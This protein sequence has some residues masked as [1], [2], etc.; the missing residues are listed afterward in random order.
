MRGRHEEGESNA[1]P[2]AG[3]KKGVSIKQATGIVR[4]AGL[5]IS[6][7]VPLPIL[8]PGLPKKPEKKRQIDNADMFR[9]KP[10][11]R[12]KRAKQ[13]MDTR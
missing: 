5:H 8:K 3:P 12:V 1:Y 11:P 6:A 10:A 4:S 2:S 9:E 7:T 13:G